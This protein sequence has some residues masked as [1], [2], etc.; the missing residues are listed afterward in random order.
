MSKQVNKTLI[1]A[2]VVG[3]IALL[4]A[5]LVIFGSGAFFKNRPKFVMYFDTSVKGL[6]VGS[7]VNFRGV[8]IGAV[9]DIQLLFNTEDLKLKIPVF[10]ELYPE[11]IVVT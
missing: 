8:P 1:G 2:F 9:T 11:R 4:V 6:N 3:A 7:P 5:A 10:I